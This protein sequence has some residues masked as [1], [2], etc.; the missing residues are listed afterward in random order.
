M[1]SVRHWLEAS[2]PK[3]LPAAVIP[4]M[5]G[6]A[7]A[8]AHGA[9]D[10]GSAAICL[11]FALLVQIGT[12]FAND[13]FD[14]VQGADTPARVGPRR[15]VAAG[16]IAPRTML[17]ATW[18]VLGVAFAV[19]LLLVRE[20]GWVLLPIGI[21]SIVCAIAYTGGPFPLGYNGLGDV[22]VFIFFGLVAVCATFYVQAGYVSPDVISCAAAIGLLAANILVA[23]NYRDAETDARVGKKTLVVRFGRKFAVWQY[24][25]SH[26][27]ALL[28]PVALIVT[29]GYRWPVLLPLVLTM[30]AM[31]LTHRLM[32]SCDPKE[33]IALLARTAGYLA[34]FGV[35]L[36]V[37]VV[38]GK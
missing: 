32:A 36:S 12:N 10:Y 14:F 13:Y 4:V 28:C 15:A 1:F 38:I 7:L 8:A 26:L 24:G 23:N 35:L 30:M 19:G 37:G 21:V 29:G 33:Q 16:L 25:L 17:A 22:F 2:R 20:G 18:L 5:V 27:V 34:L 6:T 31:R 9:A 11:A 3:T